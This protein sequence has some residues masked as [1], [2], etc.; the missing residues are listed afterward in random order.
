[1]MSPMLRGSAVLLTYLR[2]AAGG[3]TRRASALLVLLAPIA[4][5]ADSTQ[6][7]VFLGPRLFSQHSALGY[8]DGEPAHPMLQ[9][10]VAFG[11]RIGAQFGLPWLFP[12]FELAFSPT[13]TDSPKGAI[14]ADIYWLDPRMQVR[15]ELMP[16]RRIQPFL[17]VG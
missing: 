4:A 1:M 7:G 11:A 5:S 3:A 6:L 8:I 17:V 10:G 12:E 14:A 9:N 13:K 15:F 16:G 2:T